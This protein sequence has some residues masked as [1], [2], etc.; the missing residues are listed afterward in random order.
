MMRVMTADFFAR[1]P[2][3]LLP[4]IALL[5]FFG[6]F[7]AVVLRTYLSKKNRFESV[8]SLPLDEGE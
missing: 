7:T 1:S 5:V 2:V 6:V 3:L 4:I 8:A